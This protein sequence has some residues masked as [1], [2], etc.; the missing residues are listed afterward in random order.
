[1]AQ[2]ATWSCPR[3]I[4]RIT[5]RRMGD[6][7]LQL[8]VGLR[9]PPHGTHGATC[10]VEPSQ[11]DQKNYSQA[12]RQHA[13]A[14]AGGFEGS[15]RYAWRNLLRGAVPARSDVRRMGDM[16]LQLPAGLRYPPHAARVT[17]YV[18]PSRR[19]IVRHMGSMG[20]QQPVGLRYPPPATQ[21]HET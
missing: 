13:V 10:Y 18:E 11:K 17:C 14:T 16:R 7:R 21:R 3:K 4:R 6:M 9:Y 2:L 15:P 20:L 5:V 1:M 8:P 12:H 19:I